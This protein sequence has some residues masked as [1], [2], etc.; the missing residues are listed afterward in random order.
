MIL[1]AKTE[2]LGEKNLIQHGW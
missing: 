1:T 2:V